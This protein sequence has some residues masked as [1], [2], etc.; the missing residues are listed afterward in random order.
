MKTNKN[1]ELHETILKIMKT[2]QN[3]ENIETTMKPICK[4]LQAMEIHWENA[5]GLCLTR[6]KISFFVTHVPQKSF[7]LWLTLAPTDLHD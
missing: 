2:N 4:L 1:P 5:K 7:F 6:K 3:Y